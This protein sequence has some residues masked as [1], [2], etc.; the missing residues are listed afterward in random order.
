MDH[1]KDDA[2]A[3][4][5]AI[6]QA[7]LKKIEVETEQLARTR[8]ISFRLVSAV[9]LV[10]VLLT[11]ASLLGG[12]VG[13]FYDRASQRS[14]QANSVARDYMDRIFNFNSRSNTT[15]AEITFVARDLRE[16]LKHDQAR[17]SAASDAIRELIEKQLDFNDTRNVAFLSAMLT[18]WPP[19]RD[20]ISNKREADFLLYKLKRSFE[21]IAEQDKQYFHDLRFTQDKGYLVHQYTEE[22]RY[23][24]FI[25]L[26]RASSAVL[27]TA[28][29][30][31]LASNFRDNIARAL[32]NPEVANQVFSDQAISARGVD[33]PR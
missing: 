5:T 19:L 20:A 17:L 32:G 10:T 13:Y 31:E 22:P 1:N 27:A 3:L 21:Y 18:S 11:V 8:S 30:S 16:I 23:L 15:P 25:E 7:T 33:K 6:K 28:K 29:N 26:V 14:V 12:A 4:E 9:P 24:H 2:G